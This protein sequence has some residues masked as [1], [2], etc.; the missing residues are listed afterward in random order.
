[1]RYQAL[2]I[3]FPF[4]LRLRSRSLIPHRFSAL[5]RGFL[6]SPSAQDVGSSREHWGLDPFHHHALATEVDS[7]RSES[8]LRLCWHVRAGKHCA[9]LREQFCTLRHG[10]PAITFAVHLPR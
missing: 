10:V 1:M 4:P 9:L 7:C 5:A 3:Q 2:L 8:L 6:P